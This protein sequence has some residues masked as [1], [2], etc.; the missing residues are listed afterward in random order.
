MMPILPV[1]TGAMKLMAPAIGAG[2]AMTAVGVGVAATAWGA[3]LGAMT[4][5][6]GSRKS[7]FMAEFDPA[8]VFGLEGR[9]DESEPE[10]GALASSGS[11][12][13][14]RAAAAAQTMAVDLD[15]AVKDVEETGRKVARAVSDEIESAVSTAANVARKN[16]V[17]APLVPGRKPDR[18]GEAAKPQASVGKLAMKK[19]AGIDKPAAI[20]DLKK[21]VGIG[22]KLEMVLNDL[23]IYTFAQI[24]AWE[25]AEIAWIDDYLSF[26]GRIL[27]DKWIEQASELMGKRGTAKNG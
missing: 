15:S 26:A 11:P 18:K 23:G 1:P 22:P 27:R 10:T 6:I 16:P 9:W 21:I 8:A 4:G 19:P 5:V 2:A 12:A 24:A 3:W 20:D 7:P 25:A 14:A 17:S 13:G